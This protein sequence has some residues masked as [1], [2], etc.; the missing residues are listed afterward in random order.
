MDTIKIQPKKENPVHTGGFGSPNFPYDRMKEMQRLGG[1]RSRGK[2]GGFGSM[3]IADRKRIAQM[4]AKASNS[5]HTRKPKE[6]PF[7]IV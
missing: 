2:G 1:R 3:G 7:D 4:G 5:G 6:N